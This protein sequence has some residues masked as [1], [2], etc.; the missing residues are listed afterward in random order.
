MLVHEKCIQLYLIHKIIKCMH[1]FL[2]GEHM[3]ESGKWI[4]NYER[5]V[6][7]TSDEHMVLKEELVVAL[8][9]GSARTACTERYPAVL[10]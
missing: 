9:L 10:R 3:E 1:L 2:F 7:G 5:L 6:E 4:A 8:T